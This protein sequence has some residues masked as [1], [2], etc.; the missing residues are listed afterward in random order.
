MQVNQQTSAQA[1]TNGSQV[2]EGD[3]VK[4]RITERVSDTEAKVKIRGRE[5][6]ATFESGV[7]KG[8]RATVQVQGK[9]DNNVQLR[10]V[11]TKSG[12]SEGRNFDQALKK[13]NGGREVSSE[14]RQAVRSLVDG[15]S[16][17]TRETVQ[18]VQQHLQSASGSPSARME[19]VQAVASKRLPAT[20]QHLQAVHQALHHGGTMPQAAQAAAAQAGG[21]EALPVE[22]R[23]VEAAVREAVQDLRQAVERGQD[24]LQA[25]RQMQ[26][27][28]QQSGMPPAAQAAL[29]QVVSQAAQLLNDGQ[30]SAARDQLLQG[31]NQTERQ[32]ANMMQLQPAQSSAPNIGEQALTEARTMLSREPD[33]SRVIEHIRQNVLPQTPPSQQETLAQDLRQAEERLQAGREMTA[34]QLMGA[35]LERAQPQQA[36]AAHTYTAQ[37]DFQTQQPFETRVLVEDRV[38]ERL[39][40]M[41]GEFANM[42]KD[43]NRQLDQSARLLAQNQQ[44]NAPTAQQILEN[45]IKTLDRTIMRSDMMQVADMKTERQLMQASSSL[46]EAKKQLQRGN[47]QEAARI[48]REVQSQVE[49]TRFEPSEKKVKQ[50]VTHDRQTSAARTPAQTVQGQPQ[51]V[52]AQTAQQPS[53]QS[54]P[55]GQPSAPSQPQGQPA[56]QGQQAQMSAAT[57]SARPQTN[58]MF[59]TQQAQAPQSPAQQVVQAWQQVQHMAAS[60]DGSARQ[61]FEFMRSVGL[62]R[63][64]EAAQYLAANRETAA[65]STS[66]DDQRRQNLK[67][68]LLQMAK[69]EG[70]EANQDIEASLNDLTGQQLLSKEDQGAMQHLFFSLPMML[71]NKTENLEVYVNGRKQNEQVDWE[72]CDLYFHIE[73]PKL[74]ETG[75]SVEANDRQL[76]VKLQNDHPDFERRLTPVVDRTASMLEGIGYNVN[77]I[78]WEPFTDN[79]PAAPENKGSEASETQRP[80]FSEKGFDYKV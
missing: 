9:S 79:Q 59:S 50:F 75:I 70:K 46:A 13:L 20:P 36:A 3:L 76:N 6:T 17:V 66:S 11:E 38:T 16:P 44:Q 71:E 18:A 12:G 43:M 10:T 74:G 19:T 58:I 64:P 2:R 25:A 5:M 52:Q 15:G 33:A 48:V 53:A 49:A 31:L 26:Q 57:E 29:Q 4:A 27:M 73:T 47:H 35:V 56:A 61:A 1:Q 14:V 78:T 77:K 62:N 22:A 8:D 63:E 28:Q 37:A 42:K 39:Q 40:R 7:P 45:T 30:G 69:D 41:T 72:N 65:S 80:I 24:P 21:G 54:Q 60:Q 32:L 51:P 34:R 23:S 68:A 55:Q 67:H